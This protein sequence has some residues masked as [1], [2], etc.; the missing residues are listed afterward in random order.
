MP[1]NTSRR[2][3]TGR[4]P[5]AGSG[6]TGQSF[7]RSARPQSGG[8]RSGGRSRFHG[9]NSRSGA[10]SGGRSGGGGGRKQPTFWSI[11]IH[12]QEPGSS[13]RNSLLSKHKFSD[14][15]LHKDIVDT[16]AKQGIATPSPIQDQVIPLIMEGKDVIGIAET[17]SGKTAAFLLPLIQKTLTQKNQ[18]TLILT[19][20]RELALQ[21]EA[22]FRKFGAG[23]KL[24]ATSC[25]G[26][27]SIRPQIRALKR[28]TI[29]SLVRLD[30]S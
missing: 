7:N 24:Y 13:W 30:E 5:S 9:G 6:R 3:A 17:G 26:G 22:E 16:V 27:T 20:T 21:A 25:V 15:G 11:T 12:Q 23:F 18:V 4:R 2:P 14:F 19:P 29:S 8:D 10:R 28:T 1:T